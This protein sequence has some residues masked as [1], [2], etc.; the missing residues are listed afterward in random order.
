LDNNICEVENPTR[1]AVNNTL[2][3]L[4]TAPATEAP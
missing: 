3:T 1:L 4:T 2:G